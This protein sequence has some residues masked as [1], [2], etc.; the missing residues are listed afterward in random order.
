V[1]IGVQV[2][3]VAVSSVLLL[4]LAVVRFARTE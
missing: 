3:L 2:L 4:A 1:P